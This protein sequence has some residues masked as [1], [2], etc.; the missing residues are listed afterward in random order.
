M[1]SSDLYIGLFWLGFNGHLANSYQLLAV[2]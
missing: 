2:S 1:M